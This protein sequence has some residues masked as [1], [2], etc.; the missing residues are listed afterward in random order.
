MPLTAK[1]PTRLHVL[2]NFSLIAVSILA[3]PLSTI[4]LFISLAIDSCTRISLSKS[5]SRRHPRDNRKPRRQSP[6]CLAPKTILVTGV[7]MSKGLFIARA[8]HA[9]GHIVIG[10]DFEPHSLPVCGRFSRSLTRF[11][12]LPSPASSPPSLPK[13]EKGEKEDDEMVYTQ[14]LLQIINTEKVDLW[15]SCSGVM[16]A[17]ADGFA[18]DAIS[19]HTKCIALQFGSQLTRTLHEKHSFISNTRSLGLNVPE[20]HLVTSIESAMQALDV[21]GAAKTRY[22]LKSVGVEDSVRADMTLLPL[23]SPAATRAHLIAA[24]M[25]PDRPFVLQRFVRGEEYCT[26]AIVVRGHVV[27]FTA[28]G[29]AE[30]LMHYKPLLPNDGI[31]K[32]LLEYTEMAHTAVVNFGDDGLGMVNAYLSALSIS[33][34]HS[35]SHSPVFVS[36][37]TT[38]HYWIGHDLITRLF[39]PHLIFIFTGKGSWAYIF[40]SWREFAQ[41]VLYWRDPTYQLWDPLPAWW[42]Y[43]VYWPCMFL[44][45]IV[46]GKW[47]SRCNV[48]TGKIFRC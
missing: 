33:P 6:A 41:H 12:R 13:D 16:S 25:S 5:L 28:C 26:H 32:A 2:Q 39:L 11:Y 48:S 43:S 27:G 24:R 23:P 3:I 7:G 38:N 21:L 31:F 45:T 34:S 30:L 4:I 40:A 18:A 14:K 15:I 20:T 46:T 9:A 10:A 17:V 1:S 44:L 42:L 47:W 36:S 29:S 22:I 35:N 37:S 19:R 8:F